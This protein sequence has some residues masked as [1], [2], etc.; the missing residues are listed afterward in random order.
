M[1]MAT[2]WEQNHEHEHEP[3]GEL[4]HDPNLE[5]KFE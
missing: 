5:S 3:I 2:I 1:N 4:E